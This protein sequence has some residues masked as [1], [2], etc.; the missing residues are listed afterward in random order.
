MVAQVK[1]PFTVA[2]VSNGRRNFNHLIMD[3]MV[4]MGTEW[5]LEELFLNSYPVHFLGPTPKKKLGI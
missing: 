4:Q 3:L 2:V 1:D 5:Q